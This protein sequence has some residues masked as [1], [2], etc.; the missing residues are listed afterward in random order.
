MTYDQYKFDPEMIKAEVKVKQANVK[1]NL[2]ENADLLK[3]AIKVFSDRLKKD[4]LRYRDYGCYWWAVKSVLNV[5]GVTFGIN[6]D[7]IMKAEYKGNTPIET[8]VMAEM[9]RDYYLKTFVLY[10]NQFVLDSESG[11]FSEIIDSD[12]EG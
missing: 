9:F 7:P 5:Y 4:K 1:T 11:E 10:S 12:M 8:L 6:D 3:N 2:G